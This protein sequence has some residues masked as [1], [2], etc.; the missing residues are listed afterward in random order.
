[1]TTGFYADVAVLIVGFR[2]PSDVVACLHALSQAASEPSFDVFICENGGALW[3]NR[4][5]GALVEEPGPCCEADGWVM[6]SIAANSLTEA[7]RL[8][9]RGRSSNV[10]V[11]CASRNLGYAGGINAWLRELQEVPGWKGVWILNPDTEPEPL[12]LAALVERA[13]KS[14]KGM[15]GSTILDVDKHD[16]VHCRGGLHWQRLTA[17]TT[18]IGYGEQRNALHNLSAIEAALDSPSGASTYVTRPCFEKIGLMDESYFLFFEDLD[19]GVR[20]KVC[21]LGYASE[22]IVWHKRGTTTGSAKAL[23]AVPRLSVY[24]QHRNGIIFVRRHCPWILPIRIFVSCLYAVEFLL[25]SAPVNSLAAIRGLL[26]GLNGEVGEPS[27][28]L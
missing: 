13:N 7:R 10:F 25:A 14:R 18:V 17:R 9:L 28:Y 21:G 26:A 20:A 24:L 22:S 2:N 11:G 6:P 19:W 1:M 15:I 16:E 4:L 27:R 8:R 5:L 3:Y 23:D 12:A